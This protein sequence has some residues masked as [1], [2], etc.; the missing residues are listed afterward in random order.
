M[1]VED[2]FARNGTVGPNGRM[3]HDMYLLQV[4]KPGESS[5]PW[6]YFNVLATIP[7][8]KPTSIRQERLRVG[9]VSRHGD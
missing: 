3:N 1:P 2:F 9:E 7:A 6:D 4:K 5:E 8:R